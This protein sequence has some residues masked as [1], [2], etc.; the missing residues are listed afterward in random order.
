MF[1]AFCCILQYTADSAA[2]LPFILRYNANSSAIL[3]FPVEY[4]RII[5]QKG[6]KARKEILETYNQIDI[7]L[8]TFHQF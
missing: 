7:S 4:N 6:S 8:D 3:A 2:I 1:L 5:F